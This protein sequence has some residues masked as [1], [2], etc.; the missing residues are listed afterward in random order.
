MAPFTRL[1]ASVLSL[2]LQLGGLCY[3]ISKAFTASAASKLEKIGYVE[4]EGKE[5][6]SDSK[7]GKDKIDFKEVERIDHLLA[8]LQPKV[9]F[10]T[11]TIPAPPPPPFPEGYVPPASGETEKA[12]EGHKQGGD[13]A[14]PPPSIDPFI[15][16]GPAKRMKF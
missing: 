3:Y 4:T 12:A 9:N 8:S 7:T 5:E 1:L 14:Q 15:D 10:V 6:P 2:L 11:V 16:Q 13:A